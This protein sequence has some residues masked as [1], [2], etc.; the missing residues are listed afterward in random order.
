MGNIIEKSVNNIDVGSVLNMPLLYSDYKHAKYRPIVITDIT[1]QPDTP[2]L[3]NDL[4]D[5]NVSYMPI[6]TK[7]K[8]KSKF[9]Q[10]MLLK[11]MNPEMAGLDTD[12]ERPSYVSIGNEKYTTGKA[13]P[14]MVEKLGDLEYTNNTVY[15]KELDNIHNPKYYHEKSSDSARLKVKAEEFNENYRESIKDDPAMQQRYFE[16]YTTFNP[17]SRTYDIDNIQATNDMQTNYT[18]RPE[19]EYITTQTEPQPKP[20]PKPKEKYDDG[21]DF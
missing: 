16:T 12:P 9:Q 5:Y 1:E 8:K 3:S 2:N 18:N 14:S 10:D 13:F 15:D 11:I 7:F 21:P 20:R 17:T 6:T 4:N 19:K